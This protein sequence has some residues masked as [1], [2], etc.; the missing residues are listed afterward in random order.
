VVGFGC[1][2]QQTKIMSTQTQVTAQA[3]DLGHQE[4]QC[5]PEPK[6]SAVVDDESL[7]MPRR[8]LKARV[9]LEQAGAEPGQVLVRD[10]DSE[11]DVALHH[12]QEIDLAEGNVFYL[13]PECDAP[14]PADCHAP[15][16]LA[17]VVDDR[18]EEVVLANQTGLTLRD[19]FGLAPDVL[20]F[21][22]YQSPHDNPI[23][24]EDAVRFMD[25]PVFYTR[26]HKPHVITITIDGKPYE[27]HQEKATVKELKRLAGIPLADVLDKIVDGQMVPLDDNATVE[28]HCGEVFVSHP[29]D[30]A[31]S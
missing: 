10:L 3:N 21:R 23:G 30:N 19:L 24:L 18:P 22:D 29:R 6:W 27:L 4:K 14:K 9:V 13:V 20:L 8:R 25:G 26:R 15:P 11:H 28:L 1:R 2:G 5:A 31:S 16:K 7:P 12:D 17:F